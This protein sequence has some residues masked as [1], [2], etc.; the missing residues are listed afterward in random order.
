MVDDPHTGFRGNAFELTGAV[1][2]GFDGQHRSPLVEPGLSFFDRPDQLNMF[3]LHLPY[4]W[5]TPHEI[6]A[7]FLPVINTAACGLAVVSGL[8]ETD[9]YA[10]PVNLVLVK[11]PETHV[12]HVTAGDPIAQ[13]IFVQRSYRRGRIAVI[14]SHSRAAR[15][16]RAELSTWYAQRG[17]DRSA[18]K[19]LARSSHGRVNQSACISPS[20]ST[21]STSSS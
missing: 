12:V 10:N 17:N 3:K 18:Y 1:G 16:F 5:R 8:V 20:N 13:V 7:L 9:W 2:P 19:K 15:E 6:D 14:A 11:P 21:S 4:V